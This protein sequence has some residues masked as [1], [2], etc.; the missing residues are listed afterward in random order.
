MRRKLET[1][2]SQIK[3]APAVLVFLSIQFTGE[4]QTTIEMNEPNEPGEKKIDGQDETAAVS[5][6]DMEIAPVDANHEKITAVP[7]PLLTQSS[8]IVGEGDTVILVFGDGRQIYAQCQHSWKGKSPPVKI[9]KRSYPTGN[10]VGLPYGTVLEL[11][12]AGLTP[13]PEGE[14][15]IP[16]F[17]TVKAMNPGSSSQATDL[18][19]AA[20]LEDDEATAD[21]NTFPTIEQFNDNRH[22]VDNN[23]SQNLGH[24]QLERLRRAGTDGAAIGKYCNQLFVLVLWQ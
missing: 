19:N 7:D 22:L 17:T 13:L 18:E 10:L 21:D 4:K 20:S 1:G 8:N 23:T 14:E 16:G 3:S 6:T 9:H 12:V 2:T 15:L 11:G 24:V 5:T